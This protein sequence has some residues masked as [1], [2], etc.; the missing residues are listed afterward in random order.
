VLNSVNQFHNI[1]QEFT[2]VLY[3]C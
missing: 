3:S 2:A 1:L